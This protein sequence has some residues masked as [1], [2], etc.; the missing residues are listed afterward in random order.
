MPRP[1][2][3]NNTTAV[4]NLRAAKLSVAPGDEACFF[5]GNSMRQAGFELTTFGSG[6]TR[7]RRSPTLIGVAEA[8][9]PSRRQSAPPSNAR[10]VTT[11]VTTR[12]LAAL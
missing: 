3:G 1:R 5:G 7:R 2:R 10:V 9:S 12:S 4:G 11:I 8:V 6:G